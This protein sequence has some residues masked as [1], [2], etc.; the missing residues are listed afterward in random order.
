MM[1]LLLQ[2]INGCMGAL[3]LTEV[4]RSGSALASFQGLVEE[5]WSQVACRGGCAA[6]LAWTEVVVVVLLLQMW[7]ILL[8]ADA[9]QA[10]L[11]VGHTGLLQTDEWR[12][13]KLELVVGQE[14]KVGSSTGGSCNLCSYHC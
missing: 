6:A 9:S 7:P 8:K 11:K 1:L 12:D 2:L 10:D 14:Q 3:L 13:L 4:G 5:A